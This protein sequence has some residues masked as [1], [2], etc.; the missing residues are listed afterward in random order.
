MRAGRLLKRWRYVSIW[1]RDIWLCAASVQ[2]GP[3]RQE[4]W[5][6][7]DR[8][9]RRLWER[10][11]LYPRCVRLSRG[12]VLVRDGEIRIDIVLE[13]NEGFQVVS[14]SGPAY[15]WTRKQCGIRA[16][17]S[18][19]VQSEM[20]PVEAIALVDDN[21]GYHPRHTTWWWSGGD[22]MDTRDRAVAWSVIVGLNDSPVNSERTL[23][24]EGVPHEL[25]P[26]E[27]ASDL[28]SVELSDGGRLVFH[29][30]AARERRENLLLLRSSYRQPFGS[31]SG[32]LPRGTT[33]REAY[34]V[35]EHH[36]AVW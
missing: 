6:V 14:P 23:W 20:L 21:A 25:G 13:E 10:T 29:E 27:F 4:F 3:A 24:I 22:R 35:M 32:S 34:G 1:S 16:H 7:W 26:V 9:R 18:V 30:E 31:Y 28:S 5:A 33:L 15:T 36:E 2:V 8:I 12:R 17:G 11:R 19:W